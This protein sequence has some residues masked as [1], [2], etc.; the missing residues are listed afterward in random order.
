VPRHNDIPLNNSPLLDDATLT[1]HPQ[2]PASAYSDGG[3]RIISH[4]E[5]TTGSGDQHP[6]IH[7]A[8]TFSGNA[9]GWKCVALKL[10]RRTIG[11]VTET[12]EGGAGV[13]EG[14]TDNEWRG[15]KESVINWFEGRVLSGIQ[16]SYSI[17]NCIRERGRNH[18][19]LPRHSYFPTQSTS[20]RRLVVSR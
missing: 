4:G 3:D 5:P 16:Y 2:Q 8:H 10:F 14:G 9:S 12:R 11:H 19:L 20:S 6:A 15:W 17:N 13:E 7:G 1:R 18:P